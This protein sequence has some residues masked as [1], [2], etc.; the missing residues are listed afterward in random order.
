MKAKYPGHLVT[1]SF[2]KSFL[3]ELLEL[4]IYGILTQ[5]LRYDYCPMEGF[6][7]SLSLFVRPSFL[8]SRNQIS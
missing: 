2:S 3:S 5:G 8:H 4:F 1:H 7:P 6:L